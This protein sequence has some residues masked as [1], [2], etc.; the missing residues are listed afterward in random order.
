MPMDVSALDV[1]RVDG[2]V[3]LRVH[4]KPRASK[5]SVAAVRDGALDVRVAAPPVDGAANEELVRAMARAL[6]VPRSAIEIVRG[7]TSREKLIEVR[8]LAV[9]ELRARLSG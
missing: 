5:S 4:V 3:R 7:Q 1:M 9:D 8:G 6:G 2:G